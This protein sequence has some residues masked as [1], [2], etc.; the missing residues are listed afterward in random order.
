MDTPKISTLQELEPFLEEHEYET[1]CEAVKNNTFNVKT[2]RSRAC[3][4][5]AFIDWCCLWRQ[6]PQGYDFWSNVRERLA[7]T[8]G[9]PF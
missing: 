2:K 1:L 6:T 4:P 7:D 8:Y 3:S 9:G 5:A